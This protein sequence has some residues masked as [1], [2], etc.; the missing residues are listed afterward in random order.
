VSGLLA[1]CSL[2]AFASGGVDVPR[3]PLAFVENQGQWDPRAKFL[4]RRGGMAAWI[5]KEGL[6]LQLTRR[7]EDERLEGVVVRLAFEGALE[8]VV[9]EGEGRQPGVYNFFLGN[10]PSKWRTEVPGYASVL[11]R[12]LQDGVDLRVRDQEG[13]L[14][15]DLVLAPGADLDR[16][17]VRCEG[18][19]GLEV[20][21]DGRL[22]MRTV[23]GP[24]RQSPPV[25]W[26]APAGGERVPIEACFRTIGSDRFGFEVPGRDPSLALV[27]DPGLIYST[28]LGGTGHDHGRAL[29]LD[30]SGALT[31]TGETFSADFPTTAGAFDTT[32]N[33]TFFVNDVFVARFSPSSGTLLFSTF[34]GGTD[35]DDSRGI[36]LD[37]SGAVTVAG[38][39]WSFNFPTTVGAYG[40]SLNGGPDLFVTR[41]SPSGGS[42]LYSTLLGGTDTENGGALAVD[43]TGA[44]TVAGFTYSP[45]FPTTVGAYDTTFNGVEAFVSRLSPSGATLLYSTFLGGT[46]SD[47]AYALAMDSSGDHY[48]AGRTLSSNFPTTAGAYDTNFN[49]GL[50]DAFLARLS[51][52]GGTLLYSTF[53]G[54]IDDEIVGSIALDPPTGITVAGQTESPNYPT[55]PGAYDSSLNGISDGFVSKLSPSGAS[56]VYSTFLGGSGVDGVGVTRDPE[57]ATI[58]VGNTSSPDLPTTPGAYDAYYNGGFDGFAAKLSPSGSSLLYSTYFGGLPNDFAAGFAL[59][60]TGAVWVSGGTHAPAFPVTP[61]AYDTTH[62]GGADVFLLAID[63]L[64]AGT[65]SYGTST[66][67][68]TGP[69]AIGV[70][71]WPQVGNGA[72]AITCGNGPPNTTGL[73]AF[74]GAPLSAPFV[75]LGAAIWIDLASPAFSTIVAASNTLG[76]AE[77]PIPIPN[78]GALAGEWAFAQFFWV[79]PT[80]PVPCPPTGLSASNA[81]ALTVQP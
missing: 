24:V 35:V 20:E 32:F 65:F 2:V 75:F 9:L 47:E 25:A 45:S 33:G 23:L 1:G 11:Y 43:G 17:V 19:E 39:T 59:D 4:A 15:Y 64:P 29:V 71:S 37:A 79:G 66:P 7:D 57:D 38:R 70:T 80:T 36:A 77:I 56:L 67:G 27:M 53:L 13:R 50:Y 41:L 61:G 31:I 6:T 22:A 73:L 48:V 55:T 49:G 42:L 44:A 51:P 68:C 76:A 30:A 16:V 52:S 26:Y 58:I 60:A 81:L 3:L 21:S 78:A 34:L 5:E 69:L 12:G 74:S 18:T 8:T 46:A 54:G 62:N 72:F 14:E 28:F 40:T 63:Y 10:D